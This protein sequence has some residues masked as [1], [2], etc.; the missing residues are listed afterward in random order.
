MTVHV[1]PSRPSTLTPTRFLSAHGNPLSE[2]F[3]L[4][5]DATTLMVAC[6]VFVLGSA[7]AIKFCSVSSEGSACQA[8]HKANARHAL[9]VSKANVCDAVDVERVIAAGRLLGRAG[10][11]R[12]AAALYSESIKRHPQSF[13]LQLAAIHAYERA[14]CREQ[15]ILVANRSL[16]TTRTAAETITIRLL[17]AGLQ[18][19]RPKQQ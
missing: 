18:A 13:E 6:F 5:V 4:R 7:T 9:P 8:P 3:A 19:H 11:Y 17:I 16:S 12:Q 2:I 15:A 1:K 10:K 14:N